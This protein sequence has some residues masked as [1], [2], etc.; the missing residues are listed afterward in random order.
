MRPDKFN[1]IINILKFIHIFKFEINIIIIKKN[2]DLIWRVKP[3]IIIVAA[4]IIITVPATTTTT[5]NL[6]L[7]STSRPKKLGAPDP[8]CLGV[9][10]A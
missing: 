6:S 9:A 5:N 1:S 4:A 7:T 3:I 8:I 2:I 10:E